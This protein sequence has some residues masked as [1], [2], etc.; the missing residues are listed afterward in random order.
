M[1]RQPGCTLQLLK[2]GLVGAGVIPAKVIGRQIGSIYSG[3]VTMSEQVYDFGF[4][5]DAN[6]VKYAG[7][8]MTNLVL[9][10]PGNS[11]ISIWRVMVSTRKIGS[12]WIL[13]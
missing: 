6:Y 7:V 13:L 3:G 5:V 2:T 12:V 8:L 10:H 4:G 1:A 11:C 9:Q